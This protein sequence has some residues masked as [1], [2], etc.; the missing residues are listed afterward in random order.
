M[1]K[2]FIVFLL[3][4]ILSAPGFSQKDSVSYTFKT[5]KGSFMDPNGNNMTGLD[6]SYRFI[7]NGDTVSMINLDN[8]D[9]QRIFIVKYSGYYEH[10]GEWF[11]EYFSQKAGVTIGLNSKRRFTIII[12]PDHSQANYYN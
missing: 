9:D 5:T 6:L 7:K 10:N 8:P 3:L 1:K 2:C 12:Y 11:Y 4:V